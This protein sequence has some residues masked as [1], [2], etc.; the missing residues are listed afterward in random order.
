MQL[1]TDPWQAAEY[2]GMSLKTLLENYGHHHPDYLSGPRQ[3]FDRA[4]MDRQRK[5]VTERERTHSNVTKIA[6]RSR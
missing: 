3:A 5:P 4:P 2:L 6:D 1:G